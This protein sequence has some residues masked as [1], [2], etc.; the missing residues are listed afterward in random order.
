MD[1]VSVLSFYRASDRHLLN[2]C[3]DMLW[4]GVPFSYGPRNI[5]VSMIICS[6]K[7][8]VVDLVMECSMVVFAGMNHVS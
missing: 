1:V 6:R 7:W 5:R 3:F 2:L 4:E 8:D